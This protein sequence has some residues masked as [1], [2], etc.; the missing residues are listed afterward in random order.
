MRSNLTTSFIRH[1]NYFGTT[2]SIHAPHMHHTCTMTLANFSHASILD[3][4]HT[5]SLPGKYLRNNSSPPSQTEEL[6]NSSTWL[7]LRGDLCASPLSSRPRVC[8]TIYFIE[9]TVSTAGEA[10]LARANPSTARRQTSDAKFPDYRRAIGHM[11]LACFKHH[12]SAYY[13]VH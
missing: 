3:V 4:Q 10:L 11:L 6:I 2:L 13:H 9:I 7:F 12:Y 1:L 8:Q 5:S